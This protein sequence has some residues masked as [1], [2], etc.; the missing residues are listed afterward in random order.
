MKTARSPRIPRFIPLVVTT[1]LV[2]WAQ[3]VW[4]IPNPAAVYCTELGYDC[5]TRTDEH[6]NQYGVCVFPDGSECE[7]WA[8]YRKC[9][10]G[11]AS[12]DCHWPCEELPCKRAGESV[13]IGECC[14]GLV[15]IQPA[16]TYD[17]DCNDLAMIGWVFLCSD[18][19]N[20]TCESWESKCNCPEDCADARIVYVDTDAAGAND[21]T[22]WAN[23]YVYLQDALADANSAEKPVEI[24]VAQGVYTPDSNSAVPDGTGDRQA[25]FQLVNGVILKGGFAGVGES[26]PD[27]R[28]VEAYEAILSGDLSGNDVDVDDPCDLSRE[29]SRVENTFHVITGSGTDRTAVLDGFTIT[30]G[31]ASGSWSRT[32]ASN[33][34]TY[35]YEEDPSP[36]MP[37]PLYHTEGGGMY[38]HNGSPT[39]ISCVF[40]GSRAREEGGGICSKSSSNPTITNC[41]FSGN[42]AYGGGGLY[43]GNG[44]ITSCTFLTNSAD[45][46]GGMANADQP[47]LTNCVFSGNSAG[48]DGGGMYNH[49][50][51]SIVTNC[52]FSGNSAGWSGGGIYNHNCSPRITNCVFIR[53]SAGQEGGGVHNR[54]SNS[55]TDPTMINCTFA[56]NS[57]PNGSALACDSY[58]HEYPSNVQVSNCI[59]RDGGDEIW[60]NDDSTIIITYSN[61]QGGW[62]GVGNIDADP[63]FADPNG[64][65]YHLKSQAGRWDPATQAWIM[66]GVTSPCIDAGDPMS[67]IGHEPFP[68]GGAVNMGAYGGSP[69][70]S[71]SYFGE[72]VCETIVAGDINGDCKVDFADF[73]IM[74]LHWLEDDSP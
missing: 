45:W 71:K 23:A 73:L 11:D 74:A 24:R 48:R 5:Q 28:D 7:Q 60:N 62:P 65:D 68:N 41:T 56:T 10:S 54:N 70:A 14:A 63:S 6:G 66:D 2:F 51:N 34:R 18:C 31:N 38:N 57:A 8:F 53:N 21:G 69:E 64:G 55:N 37:P 25:T 22:S 40:T 9:Y 33:E 16:G 47:M 44:P 29:P 15:T 58:L 61:I 35:N 30:G 72:P 13:L 20:G 32:Q 52:T 27:V 43:G 46:G 67:P 49:Y 4:A 26:S 42:L 50:S 12:A 59:L 17:I 1:A 36:K 39:V 19:G 3:I